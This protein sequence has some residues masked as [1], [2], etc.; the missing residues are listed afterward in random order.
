VYSSDEGIDVSPN[1][2]ALGM[3]FQSYA[4]WPHLTVADNVAYPLRRRRLQ[5]SVIAEKTRD[6]L[7]LVGCGYVADRY[8]NELSGGQQQRVSLARAL[9]ASPRVLLFDE[10]LS[11]LDAGLR[12]RMRT[13]IRAVQRRIGCT[14]VYVTHDQREAMAIADQLVVMKQ[15]QVLQIGIPEEVYAHPRSSFVADFL[16]AA[17]LIPIDKV[18]DRNRVDTPLGAV[19]VSANGNPL[20]GDKLRVAVRQESFTIL[21][22]SES[23]LGRNVVELV[24][25]AAEFLGDHRIATFQAGELTIRAKL[26]AAERLVHGERYRVAFPISEALVVKDA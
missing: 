18:L 6:S 2:R 11:N 8:P 14:A 24:L 19:T 23:E 3:V 21:D 13:E 10:P 17:N 4:L 20:T 22:D 26:A 1:K 7:G 12:D 16:G 15:G 5:K 25:S 9:I